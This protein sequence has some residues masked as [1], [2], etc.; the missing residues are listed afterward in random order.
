MRILKSK[1]KHIYIKKDIPECRC[2]DFNEADNQ[3][4]GAEDD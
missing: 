3:F 4:G 1:E 2:S